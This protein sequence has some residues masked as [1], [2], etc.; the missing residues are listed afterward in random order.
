MDHDTRALLGP[1]YQFILPEINPEATHWSEMLELKEGGEFRHDTFIPS[2]KHGQHVRGREVRVRS[3]PLLRKYSDHE[4][5]QFEYIALRTPYS[6]HNQACERAVA[7]TSRACE[8]LKRYDRQVDRLLMTEECMD[9]F[10]G[11]EP[12]RKRIFGP[13][14]PARKRM[15][16]D[17]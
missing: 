6:N 1:Q 2:S 11:S 13:K 16:D 9:E 8:R 10:P 17:I 4:L 12:N 7:A 15:F 14:K 3:N 5:G